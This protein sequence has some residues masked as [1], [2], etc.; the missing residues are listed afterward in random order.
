MKNIFL[1]SLGFLLGSTLLAQPNRNA[2][3]FDPEDDA[4]LRLKWET[5]RLADPVTGRIPAG[6]RMEELEFATQLPSLQSATQSRALS[7]VRSRGPWNLGGR[8]RAV[9][10]DVTDENIILAGTANGGIW[11]STDGGAHWTRVSPLSQNPAITHIAQDTRPGHTNTWY[12][13]T[14]EGYGASSSGTGAYY[15]GGGMYKSTDGGVTWSVLTSTNSNTPHTFDNIWD[16]SWRVVTDPSDTVNDVVYASTYGAVFRSVNGG[17]SWTVDRGNNSGSSYSYFS[18]VAITSQGTVYATLSSDG[19][20]GGIW[21]KDKALGWAEI[22]PPD[23]DTA[24]F[25]RIVIGINPSN[26]NEVYFLGQVLYHGKRCT[27]YKG[28]EE[29]NSL[30][31][32]TYLSGNGTGTGGQWQDLSDHLPQDSTSQLGNFNAQGGYNLIVKVHPADPNTVFI[33]GTNLFRSTDGFTSDSNIVLIGGYDPTST[34]PF[35]RNYPNNHSDQHQLVFYASDP[36]RMIQA[37]DGGLYKTDNN[38]DSAVQWQSLSNGYVTGQF[39]S[40]AIDHGSAPNDIIMGGAQDNGTWFTRD[41]NLT[42]PWN[43]PGFGDGGYCAVEDGHAFYYMTRQEGRLGRYQLDSLGNVLSFRRIDPIGGDNYLFISPFTL[44]PN[45]QNRMYMPAGSR[46]W[47]NDSLDIIPLTGQYDTISTG[48]NMFTDSVAG[49]KISAV[50][51]CKS[52]AGRVYYGLNNKRVFRM[53]NADTNTPTVTEIT[54]TSVFPASGNVSCIAVDPNDGDHVLL[55]FSNYKVYSLY[56]SVDA[57]VTWTKVGGNLESTVAGTG[58]GP[59][60]RWVSIVPLPTGNFYLAAT[61]VGLFGAQ[62]LNGTNTVWVN[63]SPDE[64]GY[65]VCDMIDVRP[66]DGTAFIATHG[67]GIY[68]LNTSLVSDQITSVQP[69]KDPFA[70]VAS[71]YPNPTSGGFHVRYT[72]Q[73]SQLISLR[74]LDQQGRVVDQSKEMFQGRGE[75]IQG[76]DGRWAPG[77]YFVHIHG[78]ITGDAVCTLIIR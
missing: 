17:T 28:E 42:Q 36:N 26:E 21:R 37:N 55:C 75:H 41:T 44:D 9:A 57:G 22:T 16:L 18:D 68:E 27:N 62:Q 64:I 73:S 45:Q 32:Y 39:Y 40:V 35:Y 74:V 25:D 43:Q 15:L 77:T 56:E 20:S 51:A 46:L 60:V 63:L 10:I 3:P 72:L 19:P 49:A 6:A 61:S 48:W 12:A 58:A 53:D 70:M 8:T 24:V 11:R 65:T 69:V 2:S 5:E 33:G 59:S 14:G 23:I 76:W 38:L 34:I 29:W 7:A 47:R 4:L 78:S 66:S 31:K 67:S 1:L 54:G 13:T 52:P 71:V 30:L 50:T